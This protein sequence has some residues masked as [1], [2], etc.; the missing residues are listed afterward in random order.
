M[1]RRETIHRHPSALDHASIVETVIKSVEIA[2]M[3]ALRSRVV[4][5]EISESA[6]E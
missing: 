6:G 2:L 4:T 5:E 1:Y 3:I